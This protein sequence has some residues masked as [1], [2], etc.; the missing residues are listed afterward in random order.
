MKVKK[1]QK[2][3]RTIAK[4][5]P[6]GRYRHGTVYIHHLLYEMNE[7]QKKVL[8]EIRKINVAIQIEL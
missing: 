6:F 8:E 5:K 4:I 3:Y 2:D 1:T 7:K